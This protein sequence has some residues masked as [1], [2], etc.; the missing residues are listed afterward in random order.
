MSYLDYPC[1]QH[2]KLSDIEGFPASDIVAD[3]RLIPDHPLLSLSVSFFHVPSIADDVEMAL[4]ICYDST[5]HTSL[6]GIIQLFKLQPSTVHDYL[7]ESV[8]TSRHRKGG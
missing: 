2:S 5:A 4:G 3:F 6:E 8:V 7:V 1:S